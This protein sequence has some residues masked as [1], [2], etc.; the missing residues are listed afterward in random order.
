MVS[1]GGKFLGRRTELIS[2]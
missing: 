1:P 2:E